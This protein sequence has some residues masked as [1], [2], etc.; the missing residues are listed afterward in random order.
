MKWK[1]SERS[2]IV[3][4]L[5]LLSNIWII[6]N[7]RIQKGDNRYSSLSYFGVWIVA[8]QM[9]NLLK[10]LYCRVDHI[11]HPM[12]L[13]PNVEPY[14][15]FICFFFSNSIVWIR[16]D[17]CLLFNSYQSVYLVQ[18]IDHNQP[19][20]YRCQ[21]MRWLINIS[22]SLFQFICEVQYWAETIY[23]R[24][25]PLLLCSL[26]SHIHHCRLPRSHHH[27]HHRRLRRH[28]HYCHNFQQ[29]LPMVYSCNYSCNCYHTRHP[30]RRSFDDHTCESEL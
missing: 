25:W 18:C 12:F 17:F 30:R 6:H 2:G 10:E 11:N 28:H 16:I 3:W 9:S 24:L 20:N 8:N 23:Y 1:H 21:A 22:S 27:H 15:V 14:T 4:D 5:I 29:T 19:Q 13:L 26:P 7:T